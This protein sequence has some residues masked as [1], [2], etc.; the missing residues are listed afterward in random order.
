[1]EDAA[2]TKRSKL[3]RGF[4][5]LVASPC[6][7]T[8]IYPRWPEPSPTSRTAF[9]LYTVRYLLGR[10]TTPSYPLAIEE[11][12]FMEM[13]LWPMCHK[14]RVGLKVMTAVSL[15]RASKITR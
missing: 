2:S 14:I 13:T 15:M 10:V 1:M 9:L 8:R 6:S 4:K 3:H 12:Q 11:T 7:R 5:E